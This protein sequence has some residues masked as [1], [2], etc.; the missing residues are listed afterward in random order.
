[1]LSIVGIQKVIKGSHLVKSLTFDV[2]LGRVI[3]LFGPN[4]AGKSTSFSMIS[5]LLSPTSG[6]IY[7]DGVDITAL[8]LSER[9]RVGVAYLPQDSS[10]FSDLSVMDNL[11]IAHE[12]ALQCNKNHTSDF[13][14][15]LSEFRLQHVANIKASL[16]SGGERRRLEIAR[17]LINQPKYVLL[18]E[19]FAGVDPISVAEIKV[20]I[21]K[22][23]AK[24]IGVLITDHNVLETLSVVDSANVMYKGE[25]IASGT[26]S[27]IRANRSVKSLYLGES[28]SA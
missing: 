21:R 4:G 23:A 12:I 22:I 14:L 24:K 13:D 28:L 20:M 8:S 5:G 11:R 18:D 10:V 16:V 26:A 3:G 27:E 15:I 17:L 7:L 2:N 19:P 1:M 6:K 9:A 25:V